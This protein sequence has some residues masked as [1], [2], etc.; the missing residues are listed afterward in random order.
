[1]KEHPYYFALDKAKD[2]V[3]KNLEPDN[4]HTYCT[5]PLHA[6]KG[7]SKREAFKWAE[8]DFPSAP[9]VIPLKF[10]LLTTI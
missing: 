3:C 1:M 7:K 6:R 4:H 2:I 5:V 9:E 8:Q 10:F